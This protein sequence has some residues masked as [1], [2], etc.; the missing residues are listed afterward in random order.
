[1]R[2]AAQVWCLRQRA[3]FFL[4]NAFS[5]YRKQ[6]T[7][8][9]PPS[10]LINAT[11]FQGVQ[12]SHQ[13]SQ[14][15]SDFFLRYGCG[16]EFGPNLYPFKHQVSESSNEYV[17]CTSCSKMILC[18]AVEAEFGP[19]TRPWYMQGVQSFAVES[20]SWHSRAFSFSFWKWLCPRICWMH[21]RKVA[22]NAT[23]W[24]TSMTDLLSCQLTP[25]P[26]LGSCL[27]G[28]KMCIMVSGPKYCRK[29]SKWSARR[30]L[31]FRWNGYFPAIT[32]ILF[33][34]HKPSQ[35]KEECTAEPPGSIMQNSASE[36]QCAHH[37]SFV[38]LD[39][40]FCCSSLPSAA[41]PRSNGRNPRTSAPSATTV[42][43]DG[44][45]KIKK[46]H[47]TAILMLIYLSQVLTQ[48]IIFDELQRFTCSHCRSN[49]EMSGLTRDST[50]EVSWQMSIPTLSTGLNF[51]VEL[52]LPRRQT[53]PSVESA[54]KLSSLLQVCTDVLMTPGFSCGDTRLKNQQWHV[55]K[56]FQIASSKVNLDEIKCIK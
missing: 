17:L 5:N 23:P 54:D 13:V 21:P 14:Q 52:T 34:H 53:D 44:R 48:D 38:S 22:Q 12:L 8:K 55:R 6:H 37:C 11:L 29:K 28:K 42:G 18:T 32:D 50:R 9:W 3:G 30:V 36:V 49:G 20:G 47:Y 7:K 35:I 2:Q 33:W 40:Q 27:T 16:W 25:C 4:T 19:C 1:M 15:S 51:R 45:S 43:K 56:W 10:Q 46:G 39:L 31:P 24:N 26:R 41:W